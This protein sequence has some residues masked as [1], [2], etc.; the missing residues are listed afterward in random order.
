MESQFQVDLKKSLNLHNLHKLMAKFSG[1]SRGRP[2]P[3]QFSSTENAKQSEL[4]S[5]RDPRLGLKF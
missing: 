1:S 5:D 2:E 3:H 4:V